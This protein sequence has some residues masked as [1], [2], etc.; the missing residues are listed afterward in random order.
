MEDHAKVTRDVA[1]TAKNDLLLRRWASY[2]SIIVAITLV[3]A[4]ACAWLATDSLSLLASLVDAVVDVTA[5]LVTVLG[6]HYAVR[7]ADALH[8]FGHGKA[9]SMA[10]LFQAL[11]LAGSALVLI[12]DGVYRLI[13]PHALVQLKFGLG[14]IAGS[15]LL[16][17]LLVLFE[18]YVTRRTGSHAIAADRSHHLSDVVANLAVL[19]ALALIRLT[20]WP[21]F[22][23]LFAMAIAAFYG[24]SAYEIA[25]TAMDTLLDHELSGEERQQIS[26]L[27]M[28]HPMARGMHDMRTRSSGL[29][30]FI[31]FHLE[32]D[33]NLTVQH[34]HAV[35]DEI[36][37]TLK[38]ALP[39]SE[40]I[41]HVEPAGIDDERLDDRI[42]SGNA[43]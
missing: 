33:G 37:C 34:A 27:I 31:E 41:V 32:L 9:E 8:R 21:R 28:A 19:L 17:A 14:V 36:E 10:A 29:V 15:T 30:R 26:Q 38:T 20:G 11:L 24:W 13:A 22:D 1:L 7:P 16:T 5:S 23:P 4:K 42:S 3:I 25:R 43:S 12:V 2:A 39:S 35:A 40:V 18:G 6:V